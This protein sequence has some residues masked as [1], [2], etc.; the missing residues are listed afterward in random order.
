MVLI[1][2]PVRDRMSDVLVRLQTT[3]FF[4]IRKFSVAEVIEP[5]D[6]WR[7]HES[8]NREK[9]SQGQGKHHSEKVRRRVRQ[10]E[11]SGAGAERDRDRAEKALIGKPW[12]FEG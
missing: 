12:N 10:D 8:S 6:E 3:N 4:H 7:V 1:S 5:V 9:R 11:E 2:P